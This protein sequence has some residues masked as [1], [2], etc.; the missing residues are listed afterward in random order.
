MCSIPYVRKY[1]FKI[2]LFSVANKLREPNVTNTEWKIQQ[3]HISKV[4]INCIIWENVLLSLLVE[5]DNNNKLT[6]TKFMPSEYL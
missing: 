1:H 3:K 2:L 4:L 6:T 5:I